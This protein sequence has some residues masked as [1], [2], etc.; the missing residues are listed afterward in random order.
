MTLD[1]FSKYITTVAAFLGMGFGIYNFY[2]ARSNRKVI[3]KIIPSSITEKYYINQTEKEGLVSST[4]EFSEV[5]GE[6]A[7]EVINMGSFPV[8]IKSLGFKTKGSANNLH[9]VYPIVKDNGSWPR[10]LKPREGVSLYCSLDFLLKDPGAKK[11]KNAF[12]RT[13][14]GM[15]YTGTNNAL[16]GLVRFIKDETS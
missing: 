4:N 15:T 8:T 14:C 7:I 9:I 5:Y 1:I 16:K 3:L 6:F 11:I 13:T 2:I 10:R 12:A